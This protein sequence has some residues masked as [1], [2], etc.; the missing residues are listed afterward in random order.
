MSEIMKKLDDI[1]KT[2]HEIL[3]ML[4]P[5]KKESEVVNYDNTAGELH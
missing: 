2:T 1:I 3:S 4:E 5:N